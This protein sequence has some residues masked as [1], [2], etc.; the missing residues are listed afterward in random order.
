[1]KMSIK[2]AKQIPSKNTMAKRKV[3]SEKWA[4][5]FR[6]IKMLTKLFQMCQTNTLQKY[7]TCQTNTLQKYHGET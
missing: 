7:Q 1:M 4:C 6:E 2:H 5:R 3:E